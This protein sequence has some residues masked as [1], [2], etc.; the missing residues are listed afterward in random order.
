MI[1]IHSVKLRTYKQLLIIPARSSV[2]V[3]KGSIITTV[4]LPI[5]Y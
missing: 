3:M 4:Y 2:V 5:Y 1:I